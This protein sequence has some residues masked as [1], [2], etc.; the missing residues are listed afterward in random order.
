MKTTFKILLLSLF[1]WLPSL[2]RAQNNSTQEIG[3]LDKLKVQISINN[4][5]SI[6]VIEEFENLSVYTPTFV[7]QVDSPQLQDLTVTENGIKIDKKQIK[8]QGGDLTQLT[9][10]LSYYSGT[11][12]KIEYRSLNNLKIFDNRLI[13]KNIVFDQPG[14]SINQIQTNLILPDDALDSS[15]GQRS[16]AIHGIENHS[17]G[18]KS[19]SNLEYKAQN[20]SSVSSYTI[21]DT[22]QSNSI[23]FSA[24][25][26]IRFFFNNLTNFELIVFSLPLP[27][28]TLLIL[29]WLDLKYRNSVKIKRNLEPINHPPDEIAPALIDLLYRG[30]ITKFGVSATILDLIRRDTILVVDKGES[31]TFGRKTNSINLAPFEEKIIS[32]LFK[33]KK[34]KTDLGAVEKIENQELIDPIFEEVHHQIYQI[35]AERGYFVRDPYH[36]KIIHH[37]IGIFLFLISI[38]LYIL[39]IVF[40]PANPLTILPPFGITVASLLILYLAK[41]IPDRTKEGKKE[42]ERWLGFKKYLLGHQPIKEKSNQALSYLAMA[43]AMGATEE[44]ISH[45]KNLPAPTP[46]FYVSSM[47]YVATAEWMIKTVNACRSI[48]EKIEIL[49]GY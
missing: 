40:F 49:K 48:A 19:D 42:L 27:L 23:H 45:F 25:A 17:Q 10:P 16:Y 18:L 36:T 20:A 33:Q 37:L 35:G 3:N 34:I 1:L 21:E 12:L 14:V 31:I 2:I 30:E 4:D 13:I 38:I 11:D 5:S 15:Q 44:W 47:P 29:L 43:E 9:F 32:E 22:F 26:K 39:A 6:K 24:A 46:D 41:V 7:W 28:L 8:I